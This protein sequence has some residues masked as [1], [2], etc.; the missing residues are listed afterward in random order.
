MRARLV[1]IALMVAAYG[2]AS[3]AGARP[4]D[5]AFLDA[6]SASGAGA[7]DASDEGR[8]GSAGGGG[9]AGEAGS[10][11][12]AEPYAKGASLDDLAT[13][14]TTQA[15]QV[16]ALDAMKRRYPTAAFVL[17]QEK[18]DPALADY[19]DPS[20]WPNL[21]L[22]LSTMV[23]EE[24]HGWDFASSAGSTH[25]Y[26]LRSD[27]F[28]SVPELPGM[29]PRSEVLP[30]LEDDAT[31]LYDTTYLTGDQGAYDIV[32][33]GEELNA[34]VNGLAAV[35]AVAD[36]LVTSLSARDAVA[37]HLYYLE[38]YLRAGR[39]S[40]ASAYASLKGSAEWQRFVRYEWAR[41]HFWDGEARASKRLGIDA[42]RIW[43]HVA[44]A[45]NEDEIRQ[46]TGAEPTFVVCAP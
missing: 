12:Y 39:T 29:W 18:D 37:A 3:C 44:E 33:L 42:D 24:T 35:T 25:A 38:L 2:A 27:L 10:T 9:N 46:F 1:V 7:R 32:Y 14:Y 23:H 16:E 30:L 45:A 34:Y 19:A 28:L 11:C 20:S 36:Q 43:A 21:M 13:G 22:S 15:W 8:D 40:H 41:G 26:V 4:D 17:D 31:S 5:F 6:G